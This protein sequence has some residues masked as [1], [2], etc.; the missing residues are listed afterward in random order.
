MP[1]FHVPDPAAERARAEAALRESETLARALVNS[2]PGGAVFVFDHDLRYRMAAGELLT[3]VGSSPQEYEG[4]TISE[5]LPPEL[6][7]ETE[8]FVRGALAGEAFEDERTHGALVSLSRGTALRDA[9]GRITG[10][11]VMSHDITERKR[12]EANFAC[13]DEIGKD[14]ERLST[15]DEIFQAVGKRLSNVLKLSG[16][17][18]ADV[19]EARGEV[20]GNYG[21]AAAGVPTL[22]QTFR[23]EDYVDEELSR[24]SR[25]GENFIVRDT[26]TDGRVNADNYARLNIAGLVTVPFLRNGLWKGYVVAT[27]AEPRDWRPDETEL[28]QQISARLFPRIERARAEEAQ[29][30]SEDKFRTLFESMD[31]GFCMIELVTDECGRVADWIYQEVNA[32][33]EQHTGFSV[34]VGSR[35]SEV[36]PRTEQ[37]RIDSLTRVQQTGVPER[38]EGYNSDT[39]RWFTTQY[40]RVGGEGSPFIAS[41]FTDVTER[42]QREEQQ[43]YL[44]KLSDALRPLADPAEIQATATRVLGE[45]LGA[46]RVLYFEIHGADYVVERD[47]AHGA[48]SISGTFPV[49]S[50]SPKVLEAQLAGRTVAVSD[51]TAD[52]DLSPTQRAAYAAIGIAA[53]V[54]VPVV[55][56]GT[57]IAGLAIHASRPR[58]WTAAEIL[59]CE[60]TAERTWAAVERARA[61][62]VLRESEERFRTLFESIDEGFCIVELLFGVDGEAVDYRFVQVNPAFSRMTGLPADAVGKTARELVPDLEQLWIDRYGG[63]ALTGEAARF[64]DRSEPMNRWFDVYASRVGGVASRRV[65][66]VF[67]NV[68]E[69]KQ[70]EAEIQELNRVLE[71]R[72]AART[73]ELEGERASLQL[74]NEELEA[75][76]YSAS[77]DL[78]TP[79]R[80]VMA[81][82]ELAEKAME[83]GEHEKVGRSLS[84]VKQAA[85]RMNAL[86]DGM[87]VLSRSGRQQLQLLPVDLNALVTLARRDAAAEF[88]AHPVRWQI[89]DLP[90]VQ[91]DAQLLQQVMTNLLSNAV[92]YSAK[93]EVSE[94]RIW[95]Q[96]SAAEWTISVQDNGVGF[97]PDYAQRLFGIF[98]RLHTEKDFKGVGVGLATVKRIVQKHGGQVFAESDG[99]TGAT[100]S[101]VLPR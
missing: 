37:L 87:L 70:A 16:C 64:E 18:F 56:R 93:R 75:F 63:V 45:H 97:H 55:K 82:A 96:S 84:V 40:S 89:A 60:E 28:L 52:P 58:E 19:N 92:K 59:L 86:I 24:A 101:F 10:V 27:T 99:H 98:Q 54:D 30:N 50:F 76:T 36:F 23:I 57:F 22:N 53:L 8:R 39:R 9:G 5:A 79:V 11:L 62:E 32:A 31:E 61:E 47:Y 26:A 90:T 7:A 12:R 3:A 34:A 73:R 77:H 33:F 46:N 83:T 68:T 66:L 67:N 95:V 25:A 85:L 74:A 35:G 44:L 49:A 21:W 91:G 69:R 71:A 29:R 78:R 38:S 1:E 2:L 80:H 17:A 6:A 41:L 88:G 72:V 81:F 48:V 43:T 13:L 100:F 94:V 65:A 51:V 14:L 4:K 20:T 42:K 15:A